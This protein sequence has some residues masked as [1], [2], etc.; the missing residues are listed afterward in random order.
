[1]GGSG[2]GRPRQKTPVEDC[3]S[4]D[5]GKLQRDKR[6]EE[7]LHGSGWLNWTNT[8]TGEA[9]ASIFYEVDTIDALPWLRLHYTLKTAGEA[10]NCRVRLSTA[11]LPWGGVRWSFLCPNCGRDCRKLYLPNGGRIFACRLCYHLT[12]R[13]A[14]EA[15]KMD[16]LFRSLGLTPAQAKALGF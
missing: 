3:L 12:Y 1:M 13:S 2:S 6:V 16:G 15:H 11:P 10:V 7:G 9:L 14:Q 5:A 8:V 4:L